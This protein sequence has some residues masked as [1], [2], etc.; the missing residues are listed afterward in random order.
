MERCAQQ[1]GVE[2]SIMTAYIAKTVQ[3]NEYVVL[4]DNKVVAGPFATAADA[5]R[6]KEALLE[7]EP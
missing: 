2:R 5:V 4:I 1:A 3:A 7:R 6:A